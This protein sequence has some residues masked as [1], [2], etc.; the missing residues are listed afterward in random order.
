[1]GRRVCK[2][3]SVLC[4]SVF[5]LC[6]LSVCVCVC[7]SEVIAW[8]SWGTEVNQRQGVIPSS[9]ALFHQQNR[10]GSTL[11]WQK[12]LGS[13]CM[14]AWAVG[15]DKKQGLCAKT[16]W[17]KPL[18]RQINTADEIVRFWMRTEK[19]TMLHVQQTQLRE[20][21]TARTAEQKHVYFHTIVSTISRKHVKLI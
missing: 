9:S 11:H 5:L 3:K 10:V 1:M 15:K 13:L 2:S 14:A 18:W 6:V 21:N 8:C 20:I 17:R 16:C 19:Q 7:L 12:G 4:I